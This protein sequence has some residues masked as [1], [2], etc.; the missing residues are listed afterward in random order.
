MSRRSDDADT[1]RTNLPATSDRAAF[2]ARLQ[3]LVRRWPS[4]DRLARATGVSPS[5]FRKWLRG[6]AEPSRE[7]LVALARAAGVT[8]GWLAGG[9][10]PEPHSVA[11][12]GGL[13]EPQDGAGFRQSDYVLLPKRPETAAAGPPSPVPPGPTEFIALRRDWVRSALGIEPDRLLMEIAVGESMFPGIQDG[14]LLLVDASEP[15]LRSFGI[16]V[17][18]ITG[19][20][21]VKRVQPKLDGSLTLI[22]DHPSY[23]AEHISPAQAGDIRVVGRVVWSCGPPRGR[24]A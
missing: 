6:D 18:E 5:A 9:E 19:E 11:S 10:G 4:A 17:L 16:Y 1:A 15:R 22:S 14:D 20:R 13:E 12:R 2:V 3:V 7:R 23:E 8:T 24:L 21:V